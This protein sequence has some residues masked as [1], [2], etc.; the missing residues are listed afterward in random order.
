MINV[1]VLLEPVAL[2]QKFASYKFC[3]LN[4]PLSHIPLYLY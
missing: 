4:V 3:E 2:E 1:K